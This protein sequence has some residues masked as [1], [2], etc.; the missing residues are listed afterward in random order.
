MYTNQIYRSVYENNE[1]W[2]S[3]SRNLN[4]PY[5]HLWFLKEW[6]KKDIPNKNCWFFTKII[7]VCPHLK[8]FHWII[9]LFLNVYLKVF[10]ISNIK[11]YM[12]K[13]YHVIFKKFNY[14]CL[15]SPFLLRPITS[16]I[17]FCFY[18]HIVQEIGTKV[19]LV[20]DSN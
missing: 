3:Q 11:N 10:G 4:L 7:Y 9:N 17:V 18:T 12:I 20:S 5:K 15:F 14:Y 19:Y 13:I 8:L 2:I 6:L 1:F 16:K